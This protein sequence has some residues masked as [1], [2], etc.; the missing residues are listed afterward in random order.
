M[1]FFFLLACAS[2][3]TSP[4]GYPLDPATLCSTPPGF[5]V[6]FWNGVTSPITFLLSLT[7]EDTLVYAVCNSGAWYDLG[8]LL[9]VG[10][11]FGSS[12]GVKRA[13]A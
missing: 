6:G 13:R 12:S 4:S 10:A 5:W 9:G 2:I 11:V 3:P 7:H 1:I 8:F